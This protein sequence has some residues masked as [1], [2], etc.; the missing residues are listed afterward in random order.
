MRNPDV[1][2]LDHPA[3]LLTQIVIAVYT[4]KVQAMPVKSMTGFGRAAGQEGDTAWSVEIRTVNNRGFDL[5]LR[6]PQGF[7]NLE[8]KIRESIAKRIK[9]GSCTANFAVKGSLGAA[10]LQLNE[11]VLLK[12]AE[13]AEQARTV[14]GR[15]DQ[16]P[17]EALLAMKGVI[18]TAEAPATDE[19][20]SPMNDAI[21]ESF[22]AALDEVVQG[23]RS[24]GERLQ[25]ILDEKLNEIEDL[26]R[27]AEMSPERTPDAIKE[28]LRSQIDRLLPENGTFDENRLHQEAVLLAT[29]ADIEEEIK[30]LHAHVAAARD[31][32]AEDAPIGRRLEFLAQEFQREA[33]TLCSKSNA[34][35]ITRIGLSLKTAIDQLR[36]QVQN[37]E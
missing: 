34:T 3:N 15:N 21:L 30:R 32:L 29:K 13:L 1:S 33:N 6:L 25:A 19:T 18:E 31:L 12:L 27:K 23:R 17:L 28:R 11:A 8:A 10:D 20:L 16:V 35:E 37:V 5:R 26:T 7:E 22:L 2:A 9:R 36:E 24:E 4:E 14:T